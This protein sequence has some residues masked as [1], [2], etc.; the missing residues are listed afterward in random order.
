[1][2]WRVIGEDEEYM[3]RDKVE[4]PGAVVSSVRPRGL[5]PKRKKARLKSIVAVD[6]FCGVG[7]LTRG[8]LDAGVQVVAGYDI[9]QECRYPYE[10]NNRPATFK[11]KSVSDVTVE[12]LSSLYPDDCWRVLVGCAPCQPFSRYTQG[13]D[14][15]SDQKWGLLRHFARLAEAVKPHVISM[16]NVSDLQRHS[17]FH[18]FVD[19]LKALR[20]ET[21]FSVVFCPDYGVPQHRSRLVLFASLLGPVSILPPTHTPDRYPTVRVAIGHLPKLEAGK[22]SST[23]A[24][25]YSSSLSPLNLRRIRA[26]RPGGTWRDWDEELVASCHRKRMGKTYPSVYGRMEWNK[27]SPT[28][29]TQ[30]YGFG[31]GR[32]GHPEQDRAISLREGAILQSFPENYKFVKPGRE[33]CFKTIGRLV[34][35]AVPVRLG[36]VIGKS[37]EM[38]LGKYE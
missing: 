15:T 10:H 38:H 16:E 6:L 20:Y 26:S 24:L 8:L 9:A 31:N 27:P 28:I 18:E 32:F 29:T 21:T 3:G 11:K 35:N 12:E 1:M 36:E 37:I 5:N 30:F 22:T 23:D 14:A 33:Y 17:I 7:G 2:P 4:L 25:H 13:L 19:R 34:G